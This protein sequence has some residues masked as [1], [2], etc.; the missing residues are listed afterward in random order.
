MLP[1][2]LRLGVRDA[3]D[4]IVG[5]LAEM[6]AGE[7]QRS[8]IVAAGDRNPDLFFLAL[9]SAHIGSVRFPRTSII[10]H[11]D[12]T[13]R[14]PPSRVAAARQRQ[15]SATSAER[16]IVDAMLDTATETSGPDLASDDGMRRAALTYGAELR[17]YAARR[18]RNETL[19][20]DL[21][22]ETWL[23]AW[24][25][26]HQ[27]D[28][29]RGSLRA[30]LFAI[31]RNVLVDFARRQASRPV[32]SPLGRD[33]R[34]SHEADDSDAV[35]GSLALNAAIRRLTVQHREVIYH[36]H[37]RERSQDEIAQLL[38]VPVGTVRSRLFY[39]RQAL[40]RALADVG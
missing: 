39:A 22:Q 28:P 6:L 23:R 27:F 40:R 7:N 30:W 14:L 32:T 3:N 38:G 35:V 10:R 37:V 33:S 8:R 16:P 1:C 13:P 31:L 17:G 19:A 9:A 4:V 29:K 18:V 26:A 11:A 21:V 12:G 25:A 24:R 2:S 5:K 36:G 20:D 15:R 34:V